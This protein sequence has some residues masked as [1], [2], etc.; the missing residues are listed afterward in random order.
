MR[1][2]AINIKQAAEALGMEPAMLAYQL[3]GKVGPPGSS[4]LTTDRQVSGETLGAMKMA[5]NNGIEE[6]DPFPQSYYGEEDYNEEMMAIE[7]QPDIILEQDQEVEQFDS[8]V[9]EEGVDPIQS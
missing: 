1:T 9:E 7:V 5:E 8:I 6:V 2:G 4:L 3:A